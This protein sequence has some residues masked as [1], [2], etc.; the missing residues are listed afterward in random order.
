MGKKG[1]SCQETWFLRECLSQHIYVT[2]SL[3]QRLLVQKVRDCKGLGID[4]KL[5]LKPDPHHFMNK[6]SKKK[7]LRVKETWKKCLQTVPIFSGGRSDGETGET[8]WGWFPF[9]KTPYEYSLL[10]SSPHGRIQHLSAPVQEESSLERSFGDVGESPSRLGV[11]RAK[12]SKRTKL[13]CMTMEKSPE[14]I[15]VQIDSSHPS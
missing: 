12:K 5:A 9:M 14:H 8:E 15:S 6:Q 11:D 13:S 1:E 10:S 7:K 3:I 2:E 4:A